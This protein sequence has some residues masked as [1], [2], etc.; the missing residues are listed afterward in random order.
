M[1]AQPL[2]DALERRHRTRPSAL[3]L[4]CPA[5]Q[6]PF[7]IPRRTPEI[8]EPQRLPVN[9]MQGRQGINCCLTDLPTLG[10]VVTD[11]WWD[12]IAYDNPAPP[13]HEIKR[14]ANDRQILTEHNR[15]WH[16]DIRR[17]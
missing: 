15:A 8:L 13:L 16:R 3:P 10:D 6:L 12:G 14:H 9:R 4:L 5:P 1:L 7:K 17:G 2:Q 11:V